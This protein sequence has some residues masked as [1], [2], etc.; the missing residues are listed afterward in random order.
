MFVPKDV[1]VKDGNDKEVKLVQPLNIVWHALFANVVKELKTTSVKLVH[2]I[3][4]D[5]APP[6]IVIEAKELKSTDV[7]PEHPLNMLRAACSPEIVFSALKSI[8]VRLVQ[9]RNIV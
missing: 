1:G 5:A 6:Y 8:V 7:N 4:M 9:L 2:A 3:N